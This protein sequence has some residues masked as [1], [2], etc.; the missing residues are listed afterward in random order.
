M[1]AYFVKKIRTLKQEV[2]EYT[3]R[4][5]R[6]LFFAILCCFL[7]C[8]EYAV[9]RPVANSLFLANYGVKFFPYAWIALVPINFLIVNL[10]NRLIP[11]WG[12]R[13]LFSYLI[14]IV[15]LLNCFFGMTNQLYPFMTFFFYMWKEIY[16]LL[17]FQ[18]VWSIIHANI[19]IS[20]AKYLYGMFFGFGGIGAMLGS[21]FPSFFAVIYGTSTL[22][23]L[24]LPIY[25]LLFISY[26][27]MTRYCSGDTP[28]DKRDNVGGI[29]HGIRLIRHSR[30]LIFALL[31]VVF[32]QMIAAITDFQLNDF[33][34]KAFPE[35]DIRT[36]KGAQIM[37]I[38][39]TLTVTFQFIGTYFLIRS[40]GFKQ[41]HYS[42]PILI[43]ISAAVLLFSPVFAV[44]SLGFITCKTL[45][46]S[47][48][49][50]IKE[51]L[52][53]SLKPDEK[54]R[55]KAVIDVFAYRTSKAL[56]SLMIIYLTSFLS[57]QSLTWITLILCLFWTISVS[58]GLKEYEKITTPKEA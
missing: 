51:I 23:Y 8:C 47:V 9:V 37:G 31:I 48:F 41:L 18:L 17:M 45:D 57:S 3:D 54:F 25:V 24:T 22:L 6:F 39:H 55:A 33:L 21:A 52:Y 56:A 5:R 46:F 34:G 42:V 50:V 29:L 30:F 11:K 27:K 19:K 58:Y 43:A 15:I 4:E 38:I 16:V 40:I 10:Y 49:G 20:R 32:M 14:V 13:K 35:T 2:L 26:W 44:A 53:V 7:I 1:Y 36:E 12:S 28:Y